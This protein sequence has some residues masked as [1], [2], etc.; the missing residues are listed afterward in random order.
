MPKSD[1]SQLVDK[2]KKVGTEE[3]ILGPVNVNF[4]G[5]GREYFG[6]WIVNL[7]LTIITLGIYS[8]WAK[9]RRETYFKNN[10]RFFNAGFGYHATGGQIFKGRLIAFI[11]LVLV[12]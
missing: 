3:T 5:T 8:A 12:L 1:D 10:T 4:L 11:V 9:V 2:E 7:I 6:I